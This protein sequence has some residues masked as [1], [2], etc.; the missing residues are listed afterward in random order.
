MK[1]FFKGR[2]F[3][4]ITLLTGLVSASVI[5]TIVILLFSS[6]QSEKKSLTNT[7]L[8]LNYSKSNKI[9][10]SVNSLLHP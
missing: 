9:S 5:L 1:S 6:Y 4:F 3:R 8:S 10:S 7:Y 2:K